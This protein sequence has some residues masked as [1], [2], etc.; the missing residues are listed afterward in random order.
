MGGNLLVQSA[1][2]LRDREIGFEPRGLLS[3]DVF[4][5]RSERDSLG[6]RTIRTSLL[7]ALSRETGALSVATIRHTRPPGY[8]VSV[9][10]EN[11]VSRRAYLPSYSVVSANYLA[12][13]G[14]RVVEGRDL[15]T[16]D[17]VSQVG[18]AIVSRAAAR[19]FWRGE[20]PI[21]QMLTLADHGR[22]GPLVR[23]V[24]VVEDIAPTVA[25]A[26]DIEPSPSVYV[27]R[28]D[29]APRIE[30]MLVRVSVADEAGMRSRLIRRARAALPPGGV[31]RVTSF[32]ASLNAEVALRYFIAGVFIALGIL[33]LGLALFGVFSVRAHDIAHRSREFAVRISLGAT[34]SQIAR[35]VLRDSM[36]IVLAGTGLGA[37][38]AMY[39]G[40][41]LDQWLYGVF[42]TDVWALLVA[43]LILMATTVLASLAPALRAA[44]SDPVEILRAT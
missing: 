18:A 3:I 39:A 43:E 15:S 35:S 4:A 19:S 36:V 25:A 44:R 16:G 30:T 41:R 33:A 38:L 9:T 29:S 34:S 20:S 37:F 22:E 26:P 8:G 6:L 17:E 23:V 12:T 28:R 24:G 5:P 7:N 14:V 31:L 27:A 11:G 1:R 21:G 42:Y 40:R 32:L 13:L 10:L 2:E